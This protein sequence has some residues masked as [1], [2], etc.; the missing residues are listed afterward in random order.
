[1]NQEII[2]TAILSTC[3]LALFALAEI[4]YHKVK[5]NVELTRKL[6]HFGTG[7]LT[8]LFPILLNS[9][10]YVL[11]LCASFA[12]ILLLSLKYNLLQSIN[13]IERKSWG[14]LLYPLAVYL[15]YLFYTYS[16]NGSQNLAYFYL[17][18]L[19]LAI[20]DP[21]AALV[22]KSFP[23]K[24]FKI[25]KDSKTVSGCTGFFV[26]CLILSIGVILYFNP[27]FN[28]T[29]ENIGFILVLAMATMLTE[30][31]SGRGIDNLTIPA[32]VMLVIYL[33][34]GF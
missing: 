10:W 12:V 15:T 1:M 29:V 25:G 9:H 19:I 22:G 23:Y 5:V 18:I 21:I 14:S 24:K 4:L 27:S 26:S 32:C 16:P 13:A 6:V 17:P 2:N 30:A 8:L 20:C 33:N 28:F 34:H 3:F 11:F 31:L 7:I